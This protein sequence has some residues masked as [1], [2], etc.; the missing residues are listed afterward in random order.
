MCQ[1]Y[2]TLP[3]TTTTKTGARQRVMLTIIPQVP[4]VKLSLLPFW[5]LELSFLFF[6]GAAPFFIGHVPA[7]FPK[8]GS[9]G[10]G[11]KVASAL[12]LAPELTHK[13]K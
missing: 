9:L 2:L 12:V 5:G 8:S 7:S 10:S 1:L 13:G 3:L 11:G 6:F 4:L